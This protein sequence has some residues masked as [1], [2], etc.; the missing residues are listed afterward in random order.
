[1][2]DYV[3]KIEDGPMPA[4]TSAAVTGRQVLEVSGNG[5]VAPTTGAS[6]KVVGVAAFDAA[7]GAKVT[8][9]PI[10]RD[11]VH[12][13]TASGAI[14]WGDSVTSAAAGAVA[15]VV[16]ATGAAAGTRIGIAL[17]SAANGAIV[18]IQGV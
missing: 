17:S 2:A 6:T 5:T 9:K 1:M 13:L 3:P 4:T 16:A 11:S 7:S 8:V 10:T 12:R 15:T 18:D 14:T